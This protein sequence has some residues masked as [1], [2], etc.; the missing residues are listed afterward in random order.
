M[1]RSLRTILVLGVTLA[2][3]GVAVLAI[4]GAA[5][6]LPPRDPEP[7]QTGT[8]GSDPVDPADSTPPPPAPSNP[9]TTP[10][11]RALVLMRIKQAVDACPT[12]YVGENEQHEEVYVVQCPPEPPQPDPESLRGLWEF[13]L[14]SWS[15]GQPDAGSMPSHADYNK[16]DTVEDN[17]EEQ[18]E[19]RDRT[20]AAKALL[21]PP[22]D[23]SEHS[24]ALAAQIRDGV[25]AVLAS[26]L[27]PASF[28]LPEVAEALEALPAIAAGTAKQ[29]IDLE[30]AKHYSPF[31]PTEDKWWKTVRKALD[32]H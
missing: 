23:F 22:A 19:I 11:D 12:V 25:F 24:K 17:K 8:S 2:A 21:N 1:T 32:Q 29:L 13:V 9:T 4:A 31:P 28:H 30:L 6:A 3:L 7:E 14:R 26:D 15:A 10:P 16:H 18:K 5:S 27:G 20:A